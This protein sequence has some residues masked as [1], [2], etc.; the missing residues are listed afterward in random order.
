MRWWGYKR[1]HD[2]FFKSEKAAKEAA[3]KHRNYIIV[4]CME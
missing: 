3:K 1:E 2:E 4:H